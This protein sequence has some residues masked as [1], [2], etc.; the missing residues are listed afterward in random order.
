MTLLAKQGWRIMCKE[1]T[2]LHKI[3]KA[4][5]FPN[6][7]F[8]EAKLGYS[9]S[10]AW[11]GIWEAKKGLKYGCRWRVGNERDIKLWTDYWVTNHRLLKQS[12]DEIG[13]DVNQKLEDLIEKN[14]HWWGVE[15][16]NQLLPVRATVEVFKIILSPGDQMDKFI[17]EPK[18]SGL[19]SVKSAYKLFRSMETENKQ[20]ESSN[21]KEQKQIWKVL[22]KLQIQN[23]V[24]VFTWRACK[25]GLP[26]KANLKKRQVLM[27]ENCIFHG[28]GVEDVLHA[29]Y[30]CPILR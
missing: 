14:T 25:N 23:K 20:G 11:R 7:C 28:D 10:Y 21:A 22:W 6:T 30:Y 15:K 1:S 24:K 4:K 29:L 17:W 13:L 2:L 18:Q 9:P 12:V 5:F 8:L 26:T 3:Y 16:V 27:E 19:Y